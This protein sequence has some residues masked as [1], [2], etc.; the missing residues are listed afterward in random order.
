MM[1]ESK[2]R[3]GRKR[4]SRSSSVSGRQLVKLSAAVLGRELLNASP[5]SPMHTTR[6]PSRI[7]GTDQQS[8]IHA[9]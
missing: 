6:K 8:L 2:S 3:E 7:A 5:C 1:E 9:V 4:S